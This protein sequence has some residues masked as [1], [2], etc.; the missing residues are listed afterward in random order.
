M[1]YSEWFD[2]FWVKYGAE[3]AVGNAQKG[4]K[5]KAYDSWLKRLKEWQKENEGGDEQ[6]FAQH[7]WRGLD[8]QRANRRAMKSAKKFVAELPMVVTWLNQYRF[9]MEQDTPTSEIK[10]QALHVRQC[11]VAG[12]P[13]ETIGR[14]YTNEH[15]CRRHELA[16]WAARNRD[17]FKLRLQSF[18][19][20][21]GESWRD[22]S[23]RDLERTDLGKAILRRFNCRARP[24]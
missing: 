13:D 2:S 20:L 8:A 9:E 4:S 24:A 3:E 1:T 21:P 16:E 23:M 7:V 22:W 17:A 18:P 15:I 6:G 14:S 19:R 12:C 11:Y 10:R 5:R